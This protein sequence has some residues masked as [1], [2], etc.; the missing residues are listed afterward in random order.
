MN[1]E[2]KDF[3][4][5]FICHASEDKESV[6][7]PLAQALADSGF[8]IWY[9]ELSLKLGDSLRQS[10]EIG[11]SKSRYG[12]VVIS[13]HFFEKKWPQVE[14]N[15][16]FQKEMR[17]EKTI[18]PVWHNIEHQDIVEKSPIIADKIAAKMSDGIGVT[19][20][21]LLVIR[22]IIFNKK[23]NVYAKKR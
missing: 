2:A 1:S 21:L 13:P 18:I 23:G 6:A 4:D 22:Q 15:G 20:P 14:L 16:L 19:M 5:V 8:K 3:F 12:I 10:I 11:L 17:G 7:R 9:D